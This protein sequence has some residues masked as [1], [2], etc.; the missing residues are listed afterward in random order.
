MRILSLLLFGAL[1]IS[2]FAQDTTYARKLIKILASEEFHGRGYVNNGDKKSALFIRREMN[3]SGLKSFDG[4]TY[5]Q[6]FDLKANT[7][8]DEISLQI[9]GVNLTPGEDFILNASS[10]SCAGK[11][12]VSVLDSTV[13]K[14]PEA[15]KAFLKADHSEEVVVVNYL[16]E[17]QKHIRDI[18]KGLARSNSFDAK[19]VV[20]ITK[21]K[22]VF[23]PSTF[24]ESFCSFQIQKNKWPAQA[25]EMEF[26]VE[27]E[28]Y[29]NYTTN[30]VIGYIKG[31]SDSIIAISAHYDHV[32]RLGS[33][34][35]FPGANDNASGVAMLLDLAREIGQRDTKPKYSYVF[36]AFGGEESGLIGSQFFVNNPLFPLQKI[37]TLLNL[38]M[39]G[40]G[41]EGI[42]IV[43]GAVHTAD[44]DLLQQLN[45][46]YQFLPEVKARGKAANS[47]HH[48]FSEKGVKAFFIYTRG[49]HKEYHNV[50]DQAERLSLHAYEGL[51]RLILKYTEAL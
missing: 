12:P 45:S 44:F 7:F 18:M 22:P 13:F 21:N 41:E 31:E 28:F 17:K 46:Q 49:K 6:P 42:T 51:F 50:H 4:I 5:F 40:S 11:A 9:D 33:D 16:G 20:R 43:N 25:K 48:P 32:G 35:Y 26:E 39:V 8:P 30:N 38:D 23:T 3:R 10:C 34:A 1:A 29:N 24:V 36:L 2:S 37:K 15:F 19:A 47:D 27:N 14:N